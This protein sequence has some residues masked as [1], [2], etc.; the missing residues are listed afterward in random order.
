MSVPVIRYPILT[1]NTTMLHTQDI[2]IFLEKM[3]RVLSSWLAHANEK[4]D[5]KEGRRTVQTSVACVHD[6]PEAIGV[7]CREQYREPC[8]KGDCL[9]GV[10]CKHRGRLIYEKRQDTRML[11]TPS[12][13]AQNT[14][15]ALNMS[16]VWTCTHSEALRLQIPSPCRWGEE[17]SHV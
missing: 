17:C 13:H 10:G 3:K 7:S 11:I 9:R 5:N 16:P 12:E 2:M 14:C 15:R 4:V 1:H 6:C 8:L